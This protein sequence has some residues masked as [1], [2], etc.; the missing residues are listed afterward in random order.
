MYLFDA[1]TGAVLG[2]VIPGGIRLI[3]RGGTVGL[4]WLATRGLVRA[5]ITTARVLHDA[6]LAGPLNAAAARRI[7]ERQGLSSRV[8]RWW[9]QRRGLIVL[10]R[11][12]GEATQRILSPLARQEGVAASRT[13][14][15]R[16]RAMELTDQEIATF[17]ARYHTGPLPPTARLPGMGPVP[18][19]PGQGW[20]SAGIP[21]TRLPALAA[22]YADEGVV[23]I[24]RVPRATA[25]QP[26]P[27]QALEI[28]NEFIIL[29]EIPD[30]AV[31]QAVP[32]RTIAPI[33]V[34]GSGQL[35]SGAGVR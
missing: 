3:G 31:I 8:S 23:Y 25:I 28:E 33:N 19:I 13:M 10:Y 22:A 32:A 21:T 24:V 17:T 1:T 27:W 30:R 34:D 20:G 14:V 4:D 6:A 35:I 16:L 18:G 7:I 26:R 29:N 11:G 15:A 5:D 2:F 9:L 12:Q